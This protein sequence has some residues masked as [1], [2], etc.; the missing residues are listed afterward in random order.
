MAEERAGVTV[1]ASSGG[2]ASKASAATDL[3]L[4]AELTL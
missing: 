1:R 3:D 2:G 4:P